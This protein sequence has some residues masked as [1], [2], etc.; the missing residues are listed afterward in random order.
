LTLEATDDAARAAQL[1]EDL[2]GIHAWS[3]ESQLA[4]VCHRAAPLPLL[5]HRSID[6]LLGG[7]GR[8][9]EHLPPDVLAVAVPGVDGDYIG[10]V[11]AN[12]AVLDELTAAWS[13]AAAARGM[14]WE[15]LDEPAYLAR[16][17]RARDG[18]KV[19]P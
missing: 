4:I 19:S 10:L 13:R 17:A 8:T 16:I 14:G 11:C 15:V 1:F 7:G 9:V 2:P 12:Q 18:A 3:R 6:E 5:S